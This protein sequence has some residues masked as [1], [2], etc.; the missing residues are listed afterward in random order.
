MYDDKAKIRKRLAQYALRTYIWIQT[1]LLIV[2]TFSGIVPGV[3]NVLSDELGFNSVNHTSFWLSIEI[4]IL[5]VGGTVISM[6]SN[7]RTLRNALVLYIVVLVGGMIANL[8]HV[9]AS[10]MELARCTSVLCVN[11]SWVLVTLTIIYGIL[12]LVEG[13]A[14]YM[15][16]KYRMML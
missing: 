3:G 9:I 6:N 14:C 16:G 10:I 2:W 8:I 12:L 11:N 15:S 7:Q 4:L 1:F 13:L 5:A